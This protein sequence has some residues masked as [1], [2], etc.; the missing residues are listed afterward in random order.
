MEALPPLLFDGERRGVYLHFG[1]M[2][3]GVLGPA[4][5]DTRTLREAARFLFED[6]AVERAVYLGVDAELDGVVQRWAEALVG[7]D[8]SEAALWSRAAHRCARGSP[9]D[10]DAFIDAEQARRSLRVFESL[11]DADTRV[12]EMLGGALAI[13]TYDKATL[14]EEDMLPA[15]L[16][17]FGKSKV[18]IIKQV[19]QRWFLSPGSY[20]EAGIMT[21]EDRPDGLVLFLH[22]R[23]GKELRSE[24]LSVTRTPKLK[25]TAGA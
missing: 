11:P 19:G 17:L 12:V 4:N 6:R 5:G 15:R 7:T 24:R 20:E 23:H 13:L 21:L 2:R 1:V 22:D 3:L 14:T 10:I 16:L 9:E 8:A 18:P 25:V